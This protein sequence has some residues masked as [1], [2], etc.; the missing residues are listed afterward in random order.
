MN[1]A[2][3]AKRS[4]LWFFATLFLPLVLTCLPVLLL[5]WYAHQDE[6]RA[7]E[8]R[9]R[10]WFLKTN[11]AATRLEQGANPGFWAELIARRFK[12][13]FS[14]ARKHGKSV[15]N[16][17]RIARGRAGGSEFPAFRIW[18]ATAAGPRRCSL[19]QQVG[20]EGTM[21]RIMERLLLGLYDPTAERP[22]PGLLSTLFGP[23]ASTDLF[24]EALRGIAFPIIDSSG[25]GLAAWDHLEEG[26]L[27]NV[28]SSSSSGHSSDHSSG[29]SSGKSLEKS[30]AVSADGQTPSTVSGA[31]LVISAFGD[32]SWDR[33]MKATIRTW[34]PSKRSA[35]VFPAFLPLPVDLGENRGTMV[36]HSHLRERNA[37]QALRGMGTAL[38]IHQPPVHSYKGWDR[39]LRKTELFN[40][41]IRG[42]SVFGRIDL[43]AIEPKRVKQLP[44]GLWARW[45]PLGALAGHVGVLIG[46]APTASASPWSVRSRAAITFWICAW[47]L[48]LVRSVS[49]GRLDP[50]GIR[51]EPVLWF[52]GLALVPLV[53]TWSATDRFR[54]DL[55]QNMTERA[56]DDLV[57]GFSELESG[58][59][60]L[61]DQAV[62]WFR[63]IGR[64]PE[65]IKEI[66]AWNPARRGAPPFLEKLWKTC[67]QGSAD[68]R[69]V[70]VF[71]HGDF[72]VSRFARDITPRLRSMQLL[73]ASVVGKRL[74][75]L[76]DP[77]LA[78]STPSIGRRGTGI[79][80]QGLEKMSTF[81][82]E[83]GWTVAD[84]YDRIS[85]GGKITMKYHILLHSGGHVPYLLVFFWDQERVNACHLRD[86]VPRMARERGWEIGAYVANSSDLQPVSFGG[87]GR[88]RKTLDAAAHQARKVPVLFTRG[89]ELV[90]AAPC[91]GMPGFIL[92]AGMSREAH[93]RR[94]AQEDM[95][96]IFSFAGL[97]LLLFVA[98]KALSDW[99][100]TPILA[101]ERGL[102]RV[103]AGDLDVRLGIERGDEL[104]AAAETLDR[105]TGWLRERERMSRFVAP[106]VLDVVAQN[107]D[108][109]FG[110]DGLVRATVLV[111]DVRSFTTLM[112]SRPPQEVF[113]LLNRH[114]ER[115]TRIIQRCGGVIDRFVGDA[116]QAV[117]LERGEEVPELRA[118]RAAKGMRAE[119]VRLNRER[120]ARGDF[121]YEIGIG[122]AGGF[123]LGGVVG[124]PETRLDF[125]VLG[126]PVRRASELEAASKSGRS[127]RIICGSE[128][129]EK[130]N[131]ETRFIPLTGHTSVWEV[132]DPDLQPLNEQFLRSSHRKF[133]PGQAVSS[134]EVRD[135]HAESLPVQES[136]EC[137]EAGQ[138]EQA[139]QAIQAIQAE[140][141]GQAKQAIPAKQ[142]KKAPDNKDASILGEK[143]EPR[144]GLQLGFVQGTRKAGEIHAFIR[145]LCVWI[146]LWLLP[147]VLL[148]FAS[149]ALLESRQEDAE[150]RTVLRCRD[151]VRLIENIGIPDI[152]IARLMNRTLTESFTALSAKGYT[153]D[154]FQQKMTRRL[155]GISRFLGGME[156]FVFDHDPTKE[157]DF[158]TLTASSSRL[159][160]FGG[161]MDFQAAPLM[162][163]SQAVTAFTAFSA[164]FCGKCRKI[165]QADEWKNALI[166]VFGKDANRIGSLPMA[167]CGNLYR[168]GGREYPIMLFWIP[169]FKEDA[170]EVWTPE[171]RASRP[172]RDMTTGDEKLVGGVMVF[173]DPKNVNAE[174]GKRAM[175]HQFGRD[176]AYLAFS[177]SSSHGAFDLAHPRFFRAAM[178]QTALSSSRVSS[179]TG[180][181]K[182]NLYKISAK[183]R[184]SNV[185]PLVG[186]H[187]SQG[188]LIRQGMLPG[189]SRERFL[190]SRRITSSG[191]ENERIL[192]A[193][194]FSLKGWWLCLGNYAIVSALFLGRSI[195]LSLTWRLVGAFLLVLLPTLLIG[196]MTLERSGIER[197]MRSEWESARKLS[198]G[199]DDADERFSLYTAGWCAV[200]QRLSGTQRLQHTLL[201]EEQA[202]LKIWDARP[203]GETNGLGEMGQI[204]QQ[205]GSEFGMLSK[206]VTGVEAF[207][208]SATFRGVSLN[209]LLI[210]GLSGFVSYHLKGKNDSTDDLVQKLIQRMFLSALKRFQRND[211]EADQK[212]IS[213][214]GKSSRGKPAPGSELL[215]GAES[216]E[217]HD[218]MLM[219]LPPKLFAELVGAPQAY[220]ELLF[221]DVKHHL[222]RRN[223]AINYFPRFVMQGIWI[224]KPAVWHR[225]SELLPLSDQKTGVGVPK[226]EA[227]PEETP[228]TTV[229]AATKTSAEAAARAK[230]AVAVGAATTATKT[231]TETEKEG[232][233]LTKTEIETAVKM[234]T[235]SEEPFI[236]TTV[237]DEP[238]YFSSAVFG[239]PVIV[240]E[241]E[242]VTIQ[243]CVQMLP[244]PLRALMIAVWRSQSTVTTRFGHGREEQLAMGIPGRVMDRYLFLSTV[245]IGRTL[246][247]LETEGRRERAVLLGL[248]L[249]TIGLAIKTARRLLAPIIDLTAAAVRIMQGDFQVRLSLSRSDE[250]GKL[251]L[252]FNSMAAGVEA[253]ERLSR[254]VSDSVRAAA[255]DEGREAAAHEGESLEAVILFAGLSGFSSLVSSREP[256]VLIEGLNRHLAGMA[257][258]IR[259][260]RGEIDKFI[261]DK[262]LAVFH[263]HRFGDAGKAAAAALAAA[264][265]MR[266]QAASGVSIFDRPLG[267]GL[268][269]G[270]VLAGIMGTAAVRL[271]FTVI[272]D[273]VNL[274]SRL[275]D[276]A[277]H[278]D[279]GGITMD[280][281]FCDQLVRSQADPGA[282]REKPVR[283]PVNRVKGKSREVEIFGIGDTRPVL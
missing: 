197:R 124:D 72:L 163:S 60:I 247:R 243:E 185:S 267:V 177:R 135:L 141:A 109:F 257:R 210:T 114:I 239:I 127:S 77:E 91:P 174:N 279:G 120:A 182:K 116:I 70:L 118:L 44:G 53:L 2:S 65:L 80:G 249:I 67:S 260:H 158:N 274:A 31:F 139:I 102:R 240:P 99:L 20:F 146:L 248:L 38:R 33:A 115:M 220:V 234:D 137:K 76:A 156:W 277:M 150:R 32:H 93:L 83:R 208:R 145:Q 131:E 3:E 244:P 192:S 214:T 66:S 41:E 241:E 258:V 82:L 276:E 55:A 175:I 154:G 193:I 262:V 110:T 9:L 147:V 7:S 119:H 136:G 85:I 18:C 25:Y 5:T 62:N 205:P 46:P 95:H 265:G 188:Y 215:A 263:V 231:G 103:A 43:S 12:K 26:G 157:A 191:H 104:G 222:Y 69:S 42:T 17:V 152:Q 64:N 282:F 98:G 153:T 1:P 238:Q 6:E 108:D 50:P 194:L 230:V 23:G 161:K 134:E 250:L 35:L 216:E 176:G 56:R 159:L 21:R 94:L 22:D 101:M 40:P 246:A 68:L 34:K 149:S 130:N 54:A 219:V 11:E 57:Q 184:L 245:P 129:C 278:L 228:G 229:E 47:F 281:G 121:L 36:V 199:L 169:F 255:R 223:I 37:R 13:A 201:K 113:I 178:S 117:F 237:R 183:N 272:G 144:S 204:A 273:T 270:P 19:V 261:G 172:K 211:P 123:V 253:G 225:M 160:A 236:S 52:F 209:P 48:I 49:R 170:G 251:A 142:G 106:Q 132:D 227:T 275:C 39:V 162:T 96:R 87:S 259:T 4:G 140:Q 126:E 232:K 224:Q 51:W 86:A 148:N 89:D 242:L 29:K 212:K 203:A 180:V 14:V 90:Y 128:I 151:D 138:T 30:S 133:Q 171:T 73:V 100:V 10:S 79:I 97:L 74:L 59:W 202:A 283:L 198:T 111:T 63:R 58:S 45:V 84:T 266:Q 143:R 164:F 252:S 200:L 107:R 264:R 8:E 61:N 256:T 165:G 196:T 78:S 213:A 218:M 254:F 206:T 189:E 195:S 268:V 16:A 28:I 24:E 122:I 75:Q 181:F 168:L 235:E 217:L 190:L 280:G 27:A 81:S 186:G 271:E 155:A 269:F 71:G 125:T 187:Q 112:E 105:M 179:T 221:G 15:E 166:D 167:S 173:L 233:I 207:F 226:A 88:L 92:A